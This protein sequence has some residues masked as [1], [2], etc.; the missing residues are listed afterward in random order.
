MTKK[1][2]GYATVSSLTLIC[3]LAVVLLLL[4]LLEN[5]VLC[6]VVV[7]VGRGHVVGRYVHGPGISFL[8]PV[9]EVMRSNLG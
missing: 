5:V 9:Q 7:V 1:G 2:Y 3:F 4:L 6:L 8:P